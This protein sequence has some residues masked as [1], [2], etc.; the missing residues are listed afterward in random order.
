MELT[1]NEFAEVLNMRPDSE[2]VVKMFQLIDK[3]RSSF[4]S[5]REF[6]DLLVIFA[7]G[8]ADQKLKLLFD[9]YDI[10]A[11]G[12]LTQDDFISMIRYVYIV[13]R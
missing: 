11:I 12:Y 8:N 6:V 7:N 3:N 2:F 4:I 9:M 1:L 13:A 10:N 5:F